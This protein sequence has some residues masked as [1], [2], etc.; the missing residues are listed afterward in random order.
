MRAPPRARR[1]RLVSASPPQPLLQR[2]GAERLQDDA[3]PVLFCCVREER[4]S[5]QHF[6][7]YRS[8]GCV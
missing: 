3:L 2:P 4:G 6:F 8:T 7:K 5:R 1:R